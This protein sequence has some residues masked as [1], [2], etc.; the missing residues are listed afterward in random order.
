[1]SSN[2]WEEHFSREILEY[3]RCDEA[4]FLRCHHHILWS[5]YKLNKLGFLCLLSMMA[6]DLKCWV[7]ARIHA[8]M[9][10]H[11]TESSGTM[12]M[13]HYSPVQSGKSV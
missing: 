8:N 6:S 9:V 11:R 4:M 3:E 1:L 5:E 10:D 7:S 2:I 12:T 13:V